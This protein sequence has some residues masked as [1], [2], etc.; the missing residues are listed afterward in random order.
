MTRNIAMAGP[1][2][3]PA[4]SRALIACGVALSALATACASSP[5][6]AGMVSSPI[7]PTQQYG[8]VSQIVSDRVALAIHAEGLSPNQQAALADFMRRGRESGGGPIEIGPP[9]VGADPVLAHRTAEAIRA[10]LVQLGAPAPMV[11]TVAYDPGGSANPPVLASFS[12]LQPAAVDCSKTWDNLT[13]TGDNRP[14]THFGCTVTNDIAL[15][16]ADPHDLLAPAANGVSDR[17]RRQIVLGKYR[18][19]DTTSTSKDGQA[20]GQVSQ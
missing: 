15:Q 7:T 2:T 14:S 4:T 9:G 16:V 1:L 12:R 20:S 10:F 8:L 17:S 18:Q 3:R 5:Q 19:G 13:S 6:P 11:K